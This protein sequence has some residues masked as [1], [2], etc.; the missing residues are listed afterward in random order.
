MNHASGDAMIAAL[1]AL[2]VSLSFVAGCAIR[3]GREITAPRIPMQ[4]GIDG[5][6]TWFAPRL[7]GIWFSFAFTAVV[8]I[9]LLTL[10]HYQP[11]ALTSLIGAM[12]IVIATNM[13]VQVYH[14]KRVIRWQ[15]E[16][17]PK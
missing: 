16:T 13:W 2:A 7:V 3:Y 10:A 11:R 9:F 15:T 4:W 5:K 17:P 12:A 1:I 6:P 8:T 14:L